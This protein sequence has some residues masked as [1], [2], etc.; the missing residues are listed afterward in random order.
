[1]LVWLRLRLRQVSL[2]VVLLLPAAPDTW[3]HAHHHGL[4]Q[5]ACP[6]AELVLSSTWRCAGGQV[7][8]SPGGVITFDSIALIHPG[9]YRLNFDPVRCACSAWVAGLIFSSKASFGCTLKPTL[10]RCLR[11]GRRIQP[12][13]RSLFSLFSLFVLTPLGCW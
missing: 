5:V 3:T 1:M 7:H 9:F 4:V 12:F 6:R 2:L 13:N 10:A 11:P 8:S